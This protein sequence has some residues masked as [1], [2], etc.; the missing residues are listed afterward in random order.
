MKKNFIIAT[1]GRFGK[2]LLNSSEMILGK[3]EN[4]K[5]FSLEPEMSLED[6]ASCISSE[7][8]ENEEYICIVDIVGGTPFNTILYLSRQYNFRVLTGLNLP[9]F[10]EMY[11]SSEENIS[12]IIEQ[13]LDASINSTKEVKV[14][15]ENQ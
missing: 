3:T 6:F 7:L 10:L 4:C 12:K 5:A 1:H 8:N 9:M 11:L 15:G 13:G 14:G 2:E